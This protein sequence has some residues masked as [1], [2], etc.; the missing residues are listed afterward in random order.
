MK[1]ERVKLFNYRN[2][3][4]EEVFLNP[5]VNVLRGQNAQGKTNFLESIY[6]FSQAKSYRAASEKDLIKFGCDSFLLEM[7]FLT[8]DMPMHGEYKFSESEKRE[9]KFNGIKASKNSLLSEHFK[10]VLFSPEE[11]DVI[12]GEKEL[13]RNLIDDAI[14][15][16][17][18]NYAKILKDYNK[19]VKQKNILLKKRE[20]KNFDSMLDV[21]NLR[22]SEYGSRLMMYR[23]SFTR[24]LSQYAKLH[25]DEL[26]EGKEELLIKYVPF[27]EAENT[28]NIEE[29]KD[30]FNY[31]ME[32]YR[33]AEIERGQSLT[34]PHRDDIEFII[35]G[36]NVKLFGSQGQM[37]SCILCVKLAMT[38]IIKDRCGFYPVLLLD[39]I[40]S[41]LDKKRQSYLT[42]KI[43]GK[44][45]IITCTG[46]SGLRRSKRTTFFTV[47]NG[48]ITKEQ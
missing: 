18:P 45:T 15:N 29:N 31:S 37:R 11:I 22:L 8:G 5:E 47:E 16:L 24:L 42:D 44:Q 23:G 12:K 41:E 9:V 40:L 4:E 33:R 21:W 48:K 25:M 46:V 14:C 1:I 30:L 20:L 10:T 19:C 43:K 17:R 36:N 6:L 32:K 38:E 26:T 13:R 34:G 28:D 39:D 3:S 35:N 2:F 7:D 27:I